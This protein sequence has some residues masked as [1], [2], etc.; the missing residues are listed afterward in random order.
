[1]R[2]VLVATAV[3]V[4]VLAGTQTAFAGTGTTPDANDRPG[5]LDIKSA[6]QGHQGSA[7]VTHTITTFSSWRIG[8]LG[9]NTPNFF[10]VEISTDSDRAPE[11]TVLAF[12][13]QGRMVGWVFGP[14]GQFVGSATASRPNNRSVR[15]SILRSRLGS[16][17]G[18]RW[19]ALSFF[20]APGACRRGCLDRAPNGSGRVLHDLTAP[21]VSF[22]QPGVPAD[23]S[24]DV[25]FS[26][27]DT[28][29]AG[30]AQWRLERRPFGTTT[31]SPVLP[32]GTTSGDQSVPFTAAEG[33]DDEFRVV[34]SDHHGNTSTS[35]VRIVSVPEDDDSFTYNPAWTMG[36]TPDDFLDTL[37][38][39]SEVNATASYIFNGS[40]V[41]LVAPAG[42]GTAQITIDGASHGSVDLSTFTGSRQIVFQTSFPSASELTLA[43]TVIGGTVP[44]DGIIVR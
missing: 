9:T 29:G 21:T 6:S 2:Q 27:A 10:S 17:A 22:P 13:A 8:I 14:N 12:S 25:A 31:W 33:Q 11:R 5:P 32:P 28:G 26:V 1:M 20:R 36:G 42:V 7:R 39:S 16:P 30:I 43:V 35:P 41:A 3:V 18:Y 40:Y 24:Y 34:V 15:V 4:S 38:T 19:Q 44:I 37:H 23:V